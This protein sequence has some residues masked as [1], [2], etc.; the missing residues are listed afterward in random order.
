MRSAQEIIDDINRTSHNSP[1]WPDLLQ[2]YRE[3]QE[4]TY[5]S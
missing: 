4:A 2:E 5:E 3:Y 1:N